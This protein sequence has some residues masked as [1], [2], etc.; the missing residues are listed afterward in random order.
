MNSY[1]ST[2]RL[3]GILIAMV[4]FFAASGST[5]AIA[6]SAAPL[7]DEEVFFQ[8]SY[9][10]LSTKA[11]KELDNRLNGYLDL[12][13]R[14]N[15]TAE[16]LALKFDMFSK[17][18]GLEPRFNE[19]VKEF[20][21]SYSARLARGIY[22]VTDAWEKRG[23]QFASSTTDNQFK[24]FRE[25]LK[26]AQSD[27]K[28]SLGLYA[29]PVDSYRYLVRVSKGLGLGN[30]RSMLDAGLGLDSKACEIR[31]EYF[32]AI[33]PKWGGNKALMAAFLQESNKSPMSDKNK[34]RI[35]G[36]Y[37]YSL[38]HQARLDKDYKSAE[39]YLFKYYLTNKEPGALQSSGQAAL[40]G[41]F[42]KVAFERF[43]QLASEHPK[44]PYGYELRGYLYETHFKDNAK[45]VADYLVASELGA[46]WSQNRMGWYYMMGINVPTDL[47]KAKHFLELAAKQG[48]RSAA[49]NLITLEKLQ[50]RSNTDLSTK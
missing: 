14:N 10:M 50:S 37:F 6:A 5:G 31:F 43:D 23:N 34:K 29:R 11:Y 2:H 27:L 41:D 1:K 24:G 36:K 21:E 28:L 18:P 3:I 7:T 15:M 12:Y 13:A 47:N 39:T 42:K 8:E 20:P 45:A 48:N 32:D 40:D 19:W 38:A 35:E 30:E 25:I 46:N 44:Y 4:V 49:E 17:M 26:E 22:R 33:T 9:L 16:E